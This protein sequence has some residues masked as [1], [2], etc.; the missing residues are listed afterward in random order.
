MGNV[1]LIR[2]TYQIK[3]ILQN[4]SQ[5]KKIYSAKKNFLIPS[6]SKFILI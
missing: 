6:I 1:F 4:S 2:E 5:N 3:K